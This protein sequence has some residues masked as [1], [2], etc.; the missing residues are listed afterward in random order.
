MVDPDSIKETVRLAS[1]D[2]VNQIV[3]Y[4]VAQDFVECVAADVISIT[5]LTSHQ[6]KRQASN[7]PDRGWTRQQYILA[8]SIGSRT[9]ESRGARPS[10]RI[11]LW[12]VP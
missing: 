10:D 12:A 2:T 11:E 5:L 1:D 8:S 9:C 7:R 3:S 6:I 4:V